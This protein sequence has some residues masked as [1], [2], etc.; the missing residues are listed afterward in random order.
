MVFVVAESNV[1]AV[2]SIVKLP[3]VN[4]SVVESFFSMSTVKLSA[5]SFVAGSATLTLKVKVTIS[6]TLSTKAAVVVEFHLNIW[7]PAAA[8]DVFEKS[9]NL[10]EVF[11]ILLPSINVKFLGRVIFT[12]SMFTVALGTS[13]KLNVK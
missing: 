13:V 4:C 12:S 11:V 2:L 1:G 10:M 5:P 8:A 3:T 7:P 6:E 9:V